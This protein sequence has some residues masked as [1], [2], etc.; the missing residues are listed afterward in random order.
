M[1]RQASVVA[2][3]WWHLTGL[4]G[5]IRETRRKRGDSPDQPGQAIVWQPRWSPSLALLQSVWSAP[6]PGMRVPLSYVAERDGKPIGLGQ[7]RPRREAHQWEVAYLAVETPTSGPTPNLRSVPDRAASR[8][9][10]A[11][12][13]AGVEQQAD[14]ILARMSDGGGRYELFRQL[15]FSL[16]VREYSYF[17]PLAQSAPQPRVS[18]ELLAQRVPGLRPQRR[19]DAHGLLQL[20]A[21]NTPKTV[22]MVEGKRSQSWE[23]APVGIGKRLTRGSGVQRWV[24]ERE[25]EKVGWLQIQRLARGPHQVRILVDERASELNQ[26]LVDF[27]LD[28]L[29]GESGGAMVR[30]REHQERLISALEASGFLLVDAQLLMAKMLA[31]PV[32][33]PQFGRVLE[34]VV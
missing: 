9:L 14:R 28:L 24:V 7:L 17:H 34:K 30:A 19:A 32:L 2:A 5:L 21:R 13:D 10:G 4:S 12:C 29:A 3:R 22:Q 26:S 20:Y 18:P 31:T 8:L 27:A 6:V 16:A 1:Q 23:T 15:G 33:Q 11:L 25:T